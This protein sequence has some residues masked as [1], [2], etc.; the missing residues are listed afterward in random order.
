MEINLKEVKIYPLKDT[1]KRLKISDEEYFS[2]KY[3]GYI[4]NSRLK[5]INPE[6][7]GS[8]ELFDNPPHF[9]TNSLQI[10]R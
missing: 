3:S 9:T 2:K 7:G 4:S 1:V 6:E 5:Y 8:I 10:G